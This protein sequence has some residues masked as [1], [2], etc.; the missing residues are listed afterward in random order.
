[1]TT[2]VASVDEQHR[3]LVGILGRL[4][5][6]MEQGHSRAEIGILLDELDRYT[7]VHFSHEED[8]M[9][10]Y[11][12]PAA[13]RNEREHQEFLRILA[14]FRAD[15]ESGPTVK[16]VLRVQDELAWWL[17]NHIRAVDTQLYPCVRA[18]EG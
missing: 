10:R 1:M 3:Q 2:G 16:L 13:Q 4:L 17:D 15:F 7:G 5:E 12:C 18:R 8:C 14:S 9:A 11:A 6:S